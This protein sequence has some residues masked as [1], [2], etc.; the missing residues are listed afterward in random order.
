[1]SDE[2][3]S[4]LQEA[5]RKGWIGGTSGAAAMTIQ[6]CSLMWMRTTMNY[7]YRHGTSTTQAMRALWAQGGVRRFYRGIGPA[8]FQGPLARFG[9]TAANTAVL[10]LL[11]KSDMPLTMKTGVAS[12]TSAS[13]RVAIM[14]IDA[15]KT[16]L[17]A[18]GPKAVKM[19]GTKLSHQ[20][21]TVLW[22]G[23]GAAATATAVGHF[24]WFYTFNL[25]QEIVPQYKETHKKLARNAAIGFTASVVS[26]TISNSLRVI[27][28]VR[29]TYPTPISY[30]ETV[31]MVVE[32][33]GMLGLFGRGLKTRILANGLQGLMFSVLWKYFQDLQQNKS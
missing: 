18:E 27:K 5:L 23:A 33:D 19:L 28:T 10:A 7:Q 17:Q 16:T 1:M 31:Q 24:P 6:V 22:H 29:Q 32:K 26:D 14:P 8:L 21:P 13:W 20:G 11:E 3:K 15:L 30:R 2:P 4:V 9:D 12:L 25:L